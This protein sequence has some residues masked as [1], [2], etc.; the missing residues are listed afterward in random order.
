M[1]QE[2]VA[3]HIAPPVSDDAGVGP[4]LASAVDRNRLDGARHAGS[5]FVRDPGAISS[6]SANFTV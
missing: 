6:H 3:G 4:G 1:P 2:A 5:D